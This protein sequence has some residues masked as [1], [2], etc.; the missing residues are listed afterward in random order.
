VTAGATQ[1]AGARPSQLVCDLTEIA[2]DDADS[3]AII[4]ANKQHGQRKS[5]FPLSSIFSR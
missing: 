1:K 2:Q 5:G 3:S 4:L